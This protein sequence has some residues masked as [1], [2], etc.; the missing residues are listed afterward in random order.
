MARAAVVTH[1]A[2]Y[3]LVGRSPDAVLFRLPGRDVN[4]A[5]FLRAAHDLAA[6]LP[7]G[8]NIVNLCRDRFAFAVGIAAAIL[9]GQVSLLT[10][11]RSPVGLRR[12]AERYPGLCSFADDPAVASPLPHRTLRPGTGPSGGEAANPMIPAG[13]LAAIVFTS[14]STGEPVGHRKSWGQLATRSEDAGRRFGMT[15]SAP[16]SVVGMVPPQHMYGFETTVLLPWH[17]HAAA[18]CGDSFYPADVRAALAEMPEPRVLVTTPLQIRALLESGLA[19]PRLERVISATAPLFA[20]LAATAERGWNT[21]VEEIFGATEVGSIASRRTVEGDIWRAYP[22]VR[23]S[24]S[25]SEPEP[26]VTAPHAVP[27]ALSDHIE[28]LDGTRFRLLGRRTDLIKLGGRRASLAGLS[29]ILTGLE[30]VLD[31]VFV[32]PDDQEQRPNARLAAFV[33]AP[34]RDP[35]A[36]LAELRERIDP[37]FLPRRLVAVGELPRNDVGKITAD[38]ARALHD[39]LAGAE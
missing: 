36:L 11:D 26:L 23:L 5:E 16:A 24:A 8:A 4:A 38:A 10:T 27:F 21:Q 13:H 12:L 33:V 6:A 2:S 20:D 28:A 39:R 35:E 15:R 25:P 1:P 34:G 32:A 9:R 19:L 30:G 17:A 3:P 37:V 22:R 7:P 18:W 29:R 14:G 31:G